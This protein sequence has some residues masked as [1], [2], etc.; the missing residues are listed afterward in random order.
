MTRSAWISLPCFSSSCPLFILSAAV[1]T[2]VLS[3]CLVNAA[4]HCSSSFEHCS[5]PAKKIQSCQLSTFLTIPKPTALH[6]IIKRE[7]FNRRPRIQIP[8]ILVI[9]L[10]FNNADETQIP[11]HFCNVLA[12]H[13]YDL[14]LYVFST[15]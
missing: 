3:S 12:T 9:C 14:L 6:K 1:F 7:F 5:F 4:L 15:R 13:G 8:D 2:P 11:R 10:H